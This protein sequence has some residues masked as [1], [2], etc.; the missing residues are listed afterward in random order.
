[1]ALLNVCCLFDRVCHLIP[2]LYNYHCKRM[3]F[4]VSVLAYFVVSPLQ[5]ITI[6]YSAFSHGP[7]D[8]HNLSN[9]SLLWQVQYR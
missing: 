3:Y 1:M 6:V 9:S 7:E 4:R 2:R 5:P 8:V